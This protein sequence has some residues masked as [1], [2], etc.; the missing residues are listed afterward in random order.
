MAYFKSYEEPLNAVMQR[1]IS[2]TSRPKILEYGPGGSTKLMMNTAPES[3]IF[4]IEHNRKWYEHYKT[5][6]EEFSPNKPD[7]H[8]IPL[9]EN[10]VTLS[11]EKFDPRSLDLIYVDGRKRVACLD[12][13]KTLIKQEDGIIVLH[14]AE[15]PRYRKGHKEWPLDKKIWAGPKGSRTLILVTDP[16]DYE[17]L[18][19]LE[20]EPPNRR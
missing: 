17:A 16:K 13:A 20:T 11:R 5:E 19:H 15:R 8:Y 18:I 6:F 3:E 1:M 10:Y 4:C 7:L 2:K 14:D 9:K 12:L